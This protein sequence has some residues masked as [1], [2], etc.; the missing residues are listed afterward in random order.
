MHGQGSPACGGHSAWL[1]T[2]TQCVPRGA[3]LRPRGAFGPRLADQRPQYL[4]GLHARCR[5]GTCRPRTARSHRAAPAATAAGAPEP[6]ADACSL[7]R[8][9][10]GG[11]TRE[12]LGPVVGAGRR[13]EDVRCCP[14]PR[15]P[16]LQ[17]PALRCCP[18]FSRRR[19]GSRVPVILRAQGRRRGPETQDGAFLL[20]PTPASP[21]SSGQ[22]VILF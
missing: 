12:G 18:A 19:A 3:G 7:H 14:A 8:G 6:G 20:S 15:P 2:E 11:H 17:K 9:S 4:A 21:L 13:L 1:V 10:D 16:P 5:M 22:S